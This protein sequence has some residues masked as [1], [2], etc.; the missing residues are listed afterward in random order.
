MH[1]GNDKDKGEYRLVEIAIPYFAVSRAYETVVLSNK[2]VAWDAVYDFTVNR[3][4][5]EWS[6]LITQVSFIMR[7]KDYKKKI[8]EMTLKS[9]FEVTAGLSIKGKKEVL[10]L[11]INQTMAQGQGAWRILNTNQSI[12]CILPQATEQFQKDSDEVRD[13]LKKRWGIWSK[14]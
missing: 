8:A 12:A 9:F 6:E 11:T 7:T 4:D 2:E 10:H 14:K 3:I 1:T 5:D 13:L